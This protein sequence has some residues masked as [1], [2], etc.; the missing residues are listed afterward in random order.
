MPVGHY[1]KR[2]LEAIRLKIPFYA[3]WASL[4]EKGQTGL[5][6]KAI[7]LLSMP[8]GHLFKSSFLCPL[9]ITFEWLCLALPGFDTGFDTGNTPNCMIMT[10]L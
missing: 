8:V 3:R 5:K 7:R 6:K 1:F 2:I 4:F 10:F 9:G